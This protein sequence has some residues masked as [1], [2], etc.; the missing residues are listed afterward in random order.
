M[1]I[2]TIRDYCLSLPGVTEDCAF[3]PE[4]ILF[5]ICNK[6]FACI[7]TERPYL[8][9]LKCHPD[10]A[11]ELR[12]AY[13]GIAPA[14]HW[15]KRHWNDV[16]LDA[17]V[18]SKVIIQLIDHSY[19]EVVHTLP[20]KTLYNFPDLPKG[21]THC[22][23]PQTDSL[24]N[25]LHAASVSIEEGGYQLLT[26]DFQTAG[27]GQRGTSWE[28]ENGKN[29]L[30]G[31]RFSPTGVKASQ[32][33]LISEV[34]ALAACRTLRK[35]AGAEVTIKWPNDIY[36]GN[37]K[38][39]GMLIDHTICGADIA[40]TFVGIGINVNQE[41]FLS[42]APNPIS[43]RQILGK[44]VDRAAVLRNFLKFTTEG[45]N[46]LKRGETESISR[47]YHAAL[48]RSK[49]HHIFKDAEG[50][51]KAKI[52]CVADNGTLMLRDEQDNLRCYTFK[53]IE[54]LIRTSH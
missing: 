49:G 19:A 15:N 20:K 43:L 13:N 5:R 25:D 35:Y 2:E 34:V 11:I 42:N 44:E 24:M 32:Q 41:S 22:H 21:W 6:I 10:K 3:G 46:A 26:T 16:R 8:V 12:D 50:A 48:Y 53:E 33:F 36:F 47:H 51:F 18:E 14:W 45:M 37:K 4:N 38:L 1:N 9:V 40:S 7:D 52:Q 29:L 30:L 17:D 39:A 23:L 54:F 31:F 28:S 27:R